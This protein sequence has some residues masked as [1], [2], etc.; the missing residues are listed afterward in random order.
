MRA[1]AFP[2]QPRQHMPG[3]NMIAAPVQTTPAGGGKGS[4]GLD[5]IDHI[6]ACNRHNA[7]EYCAWSVNGEVQG[8][9]PRALPDQLPGFQTLFHR[10][11]GGHDETSCPERDPAPASWQLDPALATPEARGDALDALFEPLAGKNGIG[12]WRGEK[13]DVA[14]AFNRPPVLKME[15][16]F[17]PLLGVRAHGVHV[18]G[19]VRKQDGLHL[20][21]GRRSP[22]LKTFP[23]ELD[24]IVAGG[25]ASGL[26]PFDTLQK[27]A[28]EEAAIPKDLSATA[29]AAGI[30]SYAVELAGLRRDTLFCYDLE[31]PEDFTPVNTDGEV[32]EFMLWPVEKVAERVRTSFD[33][34]FNVPL[35]IIDFLIRH[36]EIGPDHPDYVA[37]CQGLRFD[38]RPAYSEPRAS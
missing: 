37:L 25:H 10:Q 18:N 33:F 29:K 22:A 30:V 9:F 26:A 7:G 12:P 8:F 32:A 31:L 5:F 28:E 2:G 38:F 23:D 4:M 17:Q 36:G 1:I 14:P 15:R 21:V 19:Y 16:C 35:V 34:K 20:W 27:E 11:S 6:L 13:V 3:L 24:N